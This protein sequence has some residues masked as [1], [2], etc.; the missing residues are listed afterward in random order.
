MTGP[1]FAISARAGPVT[2]GAVRYRIYSALGLSGYDIAAIVLFGSLAFGLGATI[3]GFGALVWHP[4]ALVPLV[5][6]NPQ[7]IRGA[8][9]R[10]S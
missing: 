8:P 4:Y 1:R 3:I 7:F 6:I 2:G 9:Q 5:P 10:S